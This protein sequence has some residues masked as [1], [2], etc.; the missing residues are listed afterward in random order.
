MVIIIAFISG[1]IMSIGLIVSGMINPQKVIGF[2]DLFGHFDP[3]LAFVMAG[4]LSVSAVGY[5]LV[6]SSKPLLCETFDL[7]KRNKIDRQLILGAVIFGVGWG[8]AGFCPGPA[9]VGV[10]LGFFKAII[11][12]IAMLTGMFLARKQVP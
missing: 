12:V 10:G 9:I 1:F 8:L 6:G 5:R 3:T 11:F 7:P 4:A 2:L